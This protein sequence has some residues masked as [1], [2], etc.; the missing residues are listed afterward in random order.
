M[1]H[2][3]KIIVVVVVGVVPGEGHKWVA[4]PFPSCS[5]SRLNAACVRLFFFSN[6][7]LASMYIA[8]I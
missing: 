4:P 2:I 6:L 7:G 3:F 5:R 1:V 8:V